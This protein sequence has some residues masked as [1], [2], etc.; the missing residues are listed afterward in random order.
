MNKHVGLFL[1]SFFG[2]LGGVAALL[3]VLTLASL[4]YRLFK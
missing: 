2:A 3:T 1:S 4:A